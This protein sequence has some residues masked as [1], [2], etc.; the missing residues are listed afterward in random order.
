MG[1]FLES[2]GLDTLLAEA[3]YYSTTGTGYLPTA[4]SHAGGRL[5]IRFTT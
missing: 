1:R 2:G 4:L 5:N 3:R